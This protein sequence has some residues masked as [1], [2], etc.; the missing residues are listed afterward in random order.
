[1]LKIFLDNTLAVPVVRVGA[2]VRC[3]DL[4]ASR[5]LLAV[6]DEGGACTVYDTRPPHPPTL[7][8]TETGA[9]SVAWNSCCEQMLCFSGNNNTLNIKAA[10]FPLHQ[11]KLMVTCLPTQL[12]QRVKLKL[13]STLPL[14]TDQLICLSLC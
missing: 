3:L 7:L 8:Y 14:M 9:N 11:Q 10:D 6:V 4:S 12:N 13:L 1:M 2:G 5:R